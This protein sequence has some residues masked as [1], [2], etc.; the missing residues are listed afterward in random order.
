MED[1]WELELVQKALRDG[2]GGC[3]EWDDKGASLVRGD[4]DLRELTP[5]FIRRELIRCI[6][7][8]SAKVVQKDEHREGYKADFKFFYMSI[9][10]ID[11]FPNGVFVEMRLT[12]ADDPE[13]PEVLIVRAHR[14]VG[15]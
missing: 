2:L 11:G 10:P 12:D 5:E 13:F 8:N 7:N 9:L 3:V 14:E 15:L 6:R 1:P 4:P